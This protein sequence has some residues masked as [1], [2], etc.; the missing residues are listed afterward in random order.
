MLAGGPFFLLLR[1]SVASAK[2]CQRLLF[3][4]NLLSRPCSVAK[5]WTAIKHNSK[6]NLSASFEACLGLKKNY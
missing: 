5:T 2:C 4:W 6:V 3:D 1:Q